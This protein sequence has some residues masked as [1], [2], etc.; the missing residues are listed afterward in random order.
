MND[1]RGS[2]E[3]S[4]GNAWEGGGSIGVDIVFCSGSTTSVALVTSSVLVPSSD[5]RSP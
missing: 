4:A 3:D 1:V 2:V 5:A